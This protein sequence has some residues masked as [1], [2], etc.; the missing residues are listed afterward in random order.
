MGKAT[1]EGQGD[2]AIK[3][4]VHFP[5]NEH[6]RR[7]ERDQRQRDEGEHRQAGT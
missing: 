7:A 4:S 3:K 5:L 6:E 1:G 2:A